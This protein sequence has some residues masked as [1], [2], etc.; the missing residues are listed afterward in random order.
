MDAKHS[1]PSVF[2]LPPADPSAFWKRRDPVTHGRCR[3]KRAGGWELIGSERGPGKYSTSKMAAWVRFVETIIGIPDVSPLHSFAKGV[4]IVSCF[5]FTLFFELGYLE[6]NR[7]LF[8]FALVFYS[9][10]LYQYGL[11]RTRL[12]TS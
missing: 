4:E 7:I 8:G 11:S 5:I 3:S 10:I 6:Q 1:A 12:Y 9:V 2:I